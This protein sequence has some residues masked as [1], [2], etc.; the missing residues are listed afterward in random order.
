METAESLAQY[1][2]ASRLKYAVL[3]DLEKEL[4]QFQDTWILSRVHVA[5]IISRQTGIPVEKILK[6]KQD[7][8]LG[9]ESYLNKVVF[10]QESALH[11]I[12]ETLLTGYAGLSDETRPLGSFLLMGPTGVGKT[13]TAKAISRYLFDSENSL[14][15]LDLSEFS[16]KH[17]VAKLIGAPAGYIGYD[18]GGILT[19]KN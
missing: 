16:E 9:L 2:E 15:R 3:P 10:G 17:S 14:V 5:Q 12:A 11:E 13:E 18:E 19:E 8:I 6:T 1:E 7:D 4:A